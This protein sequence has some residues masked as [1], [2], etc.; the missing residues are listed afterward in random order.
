MKKQ[1]KQK[2]QQQ[3]QQEKMIAILFERKIKLKQN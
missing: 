1:Q 2:Q 3:Q